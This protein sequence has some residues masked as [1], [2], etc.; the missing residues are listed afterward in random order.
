MFERNKLFVCWL[1]YRLEAAGH[2][3]RETARKTN[4]SPQMVSQVIRG[5]KASPRIDSALAR[6]L[7]YSS[8]DALACDFLIEASRRE[9]GAA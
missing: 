4:Y 2:T 9:G 7:G 6:T 1:K 3:L 5:N 8:F